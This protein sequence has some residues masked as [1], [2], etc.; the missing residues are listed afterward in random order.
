MVDVPLQAT[1]DGQRWYKN[2][3]RFA[4]I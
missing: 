1:A 2:R 4:Y 3:K